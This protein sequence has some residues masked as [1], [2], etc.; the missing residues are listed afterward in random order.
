MLNRSA[1]W[2]TEARRRESP[3]LL[4]GEGRGEG[5][6]TTHFRLAGVIASPA[7]AKATNA[8]LPIHRVIG[9]SATTTGTWC[10]S[11]SSRVTQRTAMPIDISSQ[12]H[13]R[14]GPAPAWALPAKTAR[15]ANNPA[16]G[17][18]AKKNSVRVSPLAAPSLGSPNPWG[19]P[20]T[21]ANVE[22]RLIPQTNSSAGGRAAAIRLMAS[23][24]F[25]GRFIRRRTVVLCDQAHHV[26]VCGI[27]L[28]TCSKHR[29][30]N[31]PPHPARPC[32]PYRPMNPLPTTTLL[33]AQRSGRRNVLTARFPRPHGYA[34][35][36]FHTLRKPSP[37]KSF[38]LTV[39]NSVTPWA[40]R[41]R[42]ERAS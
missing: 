8:R 20:A 24:I 9:Q 30:L 27:G 7:T 11:I 3:P 23:K 42:A 15:P 2:K 6:P 38:T 4:G 21:S 40:V 35:S 13:Q 14:T 5:G 12:F 16:E 33:R 26:S 37:S 18:G 19:P 31:S 10:H 39:A 1:S 25:S 22:N 41:V 17:N 34:L 32:S 36:G 28:P 29:F